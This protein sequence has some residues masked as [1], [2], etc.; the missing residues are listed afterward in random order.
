M[1]LCSSVFLQYFEGCYNHPTP[2]LDHF[3]SFYPLSIL[4]KIQKMHHLNVLCMNVY[5][6]ETSASPVKNHKCDLSLKTGFSCAVRVRS[7]RSG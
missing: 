4:V 1:F 7:G 3:T 6:L 2:Q 5:T